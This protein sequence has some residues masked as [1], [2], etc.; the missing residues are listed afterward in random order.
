VADLNAYTVLHP[1]D[2]PHSEDNLIEAFAPCPT[3]DN[4]NPTLRGLVGAGPGLF[5]LCPV[6]NGTRG[7]GPSLG[8]VENQNAGGHYEPGQTVHLSESAGSALVES[9]VLAPSG[10]VDL[11]KRLV[12]A[13]AKRLGLKL[14][15]GESA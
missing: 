8:L 11:D 10:V 7:G 3:C 6:C 2:V 14:V 12:L 4:E 5:K 13:A 1:L 9:G 15:D